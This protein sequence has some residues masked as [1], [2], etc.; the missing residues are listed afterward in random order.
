MDLEKTLEYKNKNKE[1]VEKRDQLKQQYK[2]LEEEIDKVEREL[3]MNMHK[4][5]VMFW[6]YILDMDPVE[7]GVVMPH[8][9]VWEETKDEF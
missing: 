5:Q 1:L 2:S 7:A 8:P 4:A 9:I 3:R 6:G